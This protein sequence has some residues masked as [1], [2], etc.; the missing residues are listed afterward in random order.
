MGTVRRRVEN[1]ILEKVST[2]TLKPGV[3]ISHLKLAKELG[4][5]S[6]P[7]VHAFRRLEGA[8][9]L[10]YMPSGETRVRPLIPREAYAGFVLRETIEGLG[11]RFCS[12]FCTDEEKAVL[13]VRLERLEEAIHQEQTQGMAQGR[14]RADVTEFHQTRVLDAEEQFHG[15]IVAFSHTP[16]LLHEHKRLVLVSLTM[17]AY[18]LQMHGDYAT[19]ADDPGHRAI[20]EAIRCRDGVEAERLMRA[21]LVCHYKQFSDADLERTE[22]RGSAASALTASRTNSVSSP[23]REERK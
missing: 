1:A 5:S 12:M 23:G 7:V 14:P 18:G 9:I 22:W 3:S 6:N 15:G 4:V 10:E 11:A 20:M 21:H 16:L 2:G 19:L 13:Q 17:T 8:G